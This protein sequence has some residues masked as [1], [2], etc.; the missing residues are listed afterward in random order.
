M[1]NSNHPPVLSSQLG[2]V[3]LSQRL[4][5]RRIWYTCSGQPQGAR[6]KHSRPTSSGTHW[7]DGCHS[8]S[9]LCF[10]GNPFW[11]LHCPQKAVACFCSTWETQ[12]R[13]HSSTSQSLSQGSSFHEG[14]V[15]ASP[16]SLVLLPF[17]CPHIVFISTLFSI[18]MSFYNCLVEIPSD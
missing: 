2:L 15:T 9:P 4:T 5:S 6:C 7:N 11:I 14:L 8:P 3:E 13:C 18:P 10:P 16:A 1:G 17:T 12:L